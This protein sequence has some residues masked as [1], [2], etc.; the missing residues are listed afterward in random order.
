MNEQMAGPEVWYLIKTVHRY[1][2]RF[3]YLLGNVDILL[4]YKISYK[5]YKISNEI[6]KISIKR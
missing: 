3:Y 1:G 2:N 5:V 6:Y 4:L